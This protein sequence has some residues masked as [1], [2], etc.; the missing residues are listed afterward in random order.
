[1]DVVFASLSG[2]QLFVVYFMASLVLLA[3]FVTLYNL[4]TPYKEMALIRAG[5][6]AAALCQGG[7]IIGFVIPICRAVSQ[8]QSLVDLV[9]WAAIAFVAQVTAW[10]ITSLLVPGFRKAIAD[11]HVAS[12]VLLAIV[13]VAIGLLNAASMTA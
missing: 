3:L 4:I 2:S 10:A 12:G 9:V 6:T 7:A 1:M 8:S 13:S 11:G 5:N